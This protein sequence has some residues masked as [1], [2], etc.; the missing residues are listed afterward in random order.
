M[1]VDGKYAS[2]PPI[3]Q[4]GE[5]VT[6]GG[7]LLAPSEYTVDAERGIVTVHSAP[8]DATVIVCYQAVRLRA[9]KEAQW[10]REVRGTRA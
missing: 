8:A 1:N 10:K 5:Q 3:T 7:R 9:R 4:Y 6:I 2:L